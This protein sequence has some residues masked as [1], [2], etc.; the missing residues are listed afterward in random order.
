MQTTKSDQKRL[1]FSGYEWTLKSGA[2]LGPG[3]NR[4]ETANVRLDAAG[5]L[6]F[7]IKG[8]ATSGWSCAEVSM[9]RRLGF[10]LYE[11]QTIGPIGGLDP[12]VV[13][14]LF[15][16]PPPD[17]GPGATNEIDIEYARWGNARNPNGNFTLWPARE[18]E[19]SV[20]HT[21]SVPAD[22]E[23]ATHRFLWL[24]DRIVWQALRGH[25]KNA[26]DDRGEFARWEF[27]PP[28]NSGLIPQKPLPVLINLWLFQGKA[29][30][31]GK[32]VSVTLARFAH[33]PR[34]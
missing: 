12:N 26:R 20:S 18:G 1:S 9:A 28:A 27:K 21:F 7:T 6:S 3:P 19:K 8:D 29:P 10:G 2:R 30:T 14:G 34:S 22:I 16:Y 23:Q 5:R 25:S 4:W 11:F 31:D 32:E 15:N 33:Y 24:P 17:V 13:L